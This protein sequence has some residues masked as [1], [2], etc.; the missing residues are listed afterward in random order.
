MENQPLYECKNVNNILNY[1]YY[2]QDT[3]EA[4]LKLSLFEFYNDIQKVKNSL[5]T[6]YRFLDKVLDKRK[7]NTILIVGPI[8][9]VKT[10]LSIV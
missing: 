9:L 1:T 6:A 10:S 4:L 5:I 8:I 3:T 2:M 7:I